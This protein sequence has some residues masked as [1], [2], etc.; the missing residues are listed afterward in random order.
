M[1]KLVPLVS[2]K[3][4]GSKGKATN[5]FHFGI[6]FMYSDGRSKK[7]SCQDIEERHFLLQISGIGYMEY[8]QEEQCPILLK[9]V[10][11]Y[12]REPLAEGV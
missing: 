11:I 12:T 1:E 6:T 3:F 4:E 2:L 9:M 5:I 8:A 7:I 10:T